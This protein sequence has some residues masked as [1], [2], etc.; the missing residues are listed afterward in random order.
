MIAPINDIVNINDVVHANYVKESIWC[1]SSLHIVIELAMLSRSILLLIHC[2]RVVEWS[3]SWLWCIFVSRLFTNGRTLI[4][5]LS[6]HLQLFDTAL[7]IHLLCH[8]DF[9]MISEKARAMVG[10]D[11]YIDE[12]GDDVTW[13]DLCYQ[14]CTPFRNESVQ[15]YIHYHLQCRPND[16]L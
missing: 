14:M 1:V 8:A 15:L 9:G 7:K 2:V 5:E 4:W 11:N 12:E 3:Y 16:D 10:F 6:S 13:F